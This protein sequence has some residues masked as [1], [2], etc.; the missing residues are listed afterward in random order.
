MSEA[1]LRRIRRIRS[2]RSTEIAHS[3]WGVNFSV[4][5]AGAFIGGAARRLPADV[6]VLDCLA[7]HVAELGVKWVRI[8]IPWEQVER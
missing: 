8:A 6:D 1:G 7:E 5:T 3:L 2:K 4:P